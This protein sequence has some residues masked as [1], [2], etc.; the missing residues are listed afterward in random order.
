MTAAAAAS[1]A[2]QGPAQRQSINRRPTASSGPRAKPTAKSRGP[3]GGI[4]VVGQSRVSDD[5]RDDGSQLQPMPPTHGY[6]V[7]CAAMYS[8][9]CLK[10][11]KIC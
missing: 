8:A 7:L 4:A 2:A 11:R 10:D 9:K 3:G 5:E 6:L 1:S